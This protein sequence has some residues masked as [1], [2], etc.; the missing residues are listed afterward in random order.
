MYNDKTSLTDVMAAL[1]DVDI[2]SSIE[3]IH[4]HMQFVNTPRAVAPPIPAKPGAGPKSPSGEAA[5]TEVPLRNRPLA[6]VDTRY[7]I[8]C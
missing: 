3:P 5:A 7:L 6:M 8:D 4:P 2:A 1:D